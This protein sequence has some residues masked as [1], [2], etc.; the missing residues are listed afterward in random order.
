MAAFLRRHP[1]FGR[2]I[3]PPRRSLRVTSNLN[4]LS[5][6]SPSPFVA[7]IPLSGAGDAIMSDVDSDDDEGYDENDFV[8][9]AAAADID[10]LINP[11]YDGS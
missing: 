2:Y 6:H 4:F 3:I 11:H 1:T 5:P 9:A 7:F 10:F 8:F